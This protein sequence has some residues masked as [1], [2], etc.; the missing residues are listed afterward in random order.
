MAHAE[1]I[2]WRI[3]NTFIDFYDDEHNEAVLTVTGS[4][5]RR[6]VSADCSLS[7]YT[8][9]LND[10]H[11]VHSTSLNDFG[12]DCG[13]S[14]ESSSVFLPSDDS[15]HGLSATKPRTECQEEPLAPSNT[16]VMIR[17]IACRYTEID[18]RRILDEAG[19][20]GA[21]DSVHVPVNYQKPSNR[22]YAFVNFNSDVY[23]ALCKQRLSG[24]KFGDAATKKLCEVALADVQGPTGKTGRPW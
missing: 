3:R 21:Y 10:C 18:V 12:T 8:C 14:H 2:L 23:V 11:A 7:K 9:I 4:S 16:S 1:K 15:S 24:R 17:H 5:R 13:S 20:A 6:S 19:F 22:G